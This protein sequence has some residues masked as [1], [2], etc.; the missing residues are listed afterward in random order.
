MKIGFLI[1]LISL[2]SIANGND[3]IDCTLTKKSNRDF[4]SCESKIKGYVKQNEEINEIELK[5][6]N[7]TGI[8]QTLTIDSVK[9]ISEIN[10]V[11]KINTL[12]NSKNIK[13]FKTPKVTAINISSKSP[14][15]RDPEMLM[16]SSGCHIVNA[17][18]VISY[19]VDNKCNDILCSASVECLENNKKSTLDAICK[20]IQA[21]E[22]VFC[23][24]A[25]K[26][27]SD[28]Y[29]SIEP[30]T[31]RTNSN[32]EQATGTRGITK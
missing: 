28:T 15:Y 7:S 18:V 24:N 27:L 14:L 16:L 2:L 17:P 19:P 32:T 21:K 6:L 31:E 8:E 13:N 11:E 12:L 23:P 29:V 25:E 26:C 30:Y 10:S 1:C 5:F 20:A 22:G 9:Q 4:L 3:N